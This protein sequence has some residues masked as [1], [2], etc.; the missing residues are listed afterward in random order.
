VKTPGIGARASLARSGVWDAAYGHRHSPT[1][2]KTLLKGYCPLVG[3]SDCR[4]AGRLVIPA[5]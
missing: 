2:T 1:T 3:S 4:A 5:E